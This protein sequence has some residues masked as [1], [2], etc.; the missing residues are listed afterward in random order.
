MF[1][2]DVVIHT[3]PGRSSL[4][5][6]HQPV[7]P[8]PTS[9]GSTASQDVPPPNGGTCAAL[10]YIHRERPSCGSRGGRPTGPL[11]GSGPGARGSHPRRSP[12]GRQ[13]RAGRTTRRYPEMPYERPA[14]Y[15]YRRSCCGT[16]VPRTGW[17]VA[18]S[19]TMQARWSSL[20][21]LRIP[22]LIEVDNIDRRRPDAVEMSVIVASCRA[23]A[24]ARSPPR[25]RRWEWGRSPAGHRPSPSV[26][27][28]ARRP[29][30]SPSA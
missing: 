29:P 26:R 27:R 11:P 23:A 12:T 5:Q 25:L 24:T 13:P 10:R 8:S 7:S 22:R 6:D 9:V 4:I 1:G 15:C 19:E 14:A 3:E 16:R 21:G 28:P 17:P 30:W 20:P 18:C 2:V